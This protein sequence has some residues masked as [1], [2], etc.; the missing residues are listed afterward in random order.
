MASISARREVLLRIKSLVATRLFNSGR[1]DLQEW[2]REA[3]G[4]IARLSESSEGDF[5]S[6]VR[7]LL[8]RLNCSHVAFFHVASQPSR[9]QHS[10]GVTLRSA[11]SRSVECWMVLDVFPESVAQNAGIRPGQFLMS[12]DGKG[13]LPPNMP[14]F[15]F[16]EKYTVDLQSP[17]G[18]DNVVVQVQLP[19][20]KR[21][22]RRPPLIEPKPVTATMLT[23][24]IGMLR[25]PF[26]SGAFGIRFSKLLDDEIDALKAKGCTGLVVDLRGCIGGSLG[27]ASLT[28][29]F[30]PG[31]IPIGYDI[32]RS[33]LEKGYSTSELPRVPMPTSR[34]ELLICLARF[35]IQDKSLMLLT[36]GL[37]AQPFH[38]RIA[39]LV[40]EFTA[41]AGEMAAQ[42]AKDTALAMLVGRR[43]MGHVLGSTMFDAGHGYKV[44]L[45]IFGWY[46]PDGSQTERSGVEPDYAVDIDPEALYAGHDAQLASALQL[47][48]N[49]PKN[50]TRA[51]SR[52]V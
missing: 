44:A 9:P 45:P 28:S 33:R 1:V 17:S 8:S 51:A 12:V 37:G 52:T 5:E 15:R 31:R 26:F 23:P 49:E 46:R 41:S 40:N 19:T 14:E 3:D 6:V 25:I 24:D 21:G 30:T 7:D 10:I 38:G 50:T 29:Y 32:T 27:F 13:Y 39:I 42:F 2:S 20:R 18:S 35:S 43:T 22:G 34:S 47:L 16:G 48:T 4:E 36:Q 11:A